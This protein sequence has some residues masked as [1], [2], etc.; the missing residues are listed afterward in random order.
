[1]M[2]IRVDGLGEINDFAASVFDFIPEPVGVDIGVIE[3]GAVQMVGRS[4]RFVSEIVRQFPVNVR[5]GVALAAIP[6]PVAESV[7]EKSV[8]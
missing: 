6:S 4:D 8:L 5:C 7:A 2:R 3:M 1:M